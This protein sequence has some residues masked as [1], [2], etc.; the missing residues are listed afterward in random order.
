M[1]TNA[2]PG[3][4]GAPNQGTQLLAAGKQNVAHALA[5]FQILKW[6]NPSGKKC[7]P[8]VAGGRSYDMLSFDMFEHQAPKNVR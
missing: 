1:Q 4:L 7:L 6:P 3:A 2:N 8:L 5:R